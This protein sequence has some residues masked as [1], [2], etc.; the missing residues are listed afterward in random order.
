MSV[1]LTENNAEGIAI[2]HIDSWRST[3][4]GIISDSV[5]S[6][7][8][9]EKRKNSWLW[10]FN[11]PNDDEKI[12]VAEDINGGIIGF[13]NGGRSR[14]DEFKQDGELYA[15]YLMK[16]HQ[17]LGIGKLLLNVIVNSLKV[18]NYSSIMLWV[19]NDNPSVGFYQALGGRVIGQKEIIIGET[20]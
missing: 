10:T 18:N 1:A 6:E 8:S 13:A 14:N 5:L 16:D 20:A 9:V 12:Y 2:A 7:L 11:N 3:Y 17:G 19:L 4:K 15:I